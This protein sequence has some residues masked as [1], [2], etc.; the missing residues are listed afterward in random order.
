MATG[1][2]VESWWGGFCAL[3]HDGN[4][5]RLSNITTFTTSLQ[6]DAGVSA[7]QAQYHNC[8][9]PKGGAGTRWA[10]FL[11]ALDAQQMHTPTLPLSAPPGSPT[12]TG[13][14]GAPSQ[15]SLR[16]ERIDIRGTGGLVVRQ[17]NLPLTRLKVAQMLP[18]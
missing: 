6:G 5:P 3:V 15:R 17:L 14:V 11:F 10:G 9:G 4:P 18:H 1:T 7:L 2:A 8:T 16:V 12:I 13:I